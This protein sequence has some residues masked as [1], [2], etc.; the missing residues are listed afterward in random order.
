MNGHKP[1]E[2]WFSAVADDLLDAWEVAVSEAGEPDASDEELAAA[3]REITD[4]DV[5]Q[6]IA[7]LKGFG[8]P[9]AMAADEWQTV[10]DLADVLRGD[11]EIP[12]LDD[13]R[14]VLNAGWKVRIDDQ[15]DKSGDDAPVAA[16]GD[17][18]SR[19]LAATAQA[20]AT[21]SGRDRAPTVRR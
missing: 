14:A 19:M 21:G 10:V 15:L 16:L 2:Q 4:D 17:K 11:G 18:V 8:L 5:A 1:T 12:M 13:P 9:R 3:G 20:S 7:A 6:A